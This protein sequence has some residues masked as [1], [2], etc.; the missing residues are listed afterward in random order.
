MST[1]LTLPLMTVEQFFA[2]PEPTG[3]F[4]CELHFGELIEVSR[5]NKRHFDLQSRIRDILVRNLNS[6]LWRIDIEMPYGL[7]AGYDARAA[8]VGVSRRE[9]WDA[10]PQD[11]YLIGSPDLV[12]EIKSRSN[13]DR[14]MEADAIAHITHGATA[15]ALVNPD[16]GEVIVVTASART[17]YGRADRIDSRPAFHVYLNGGNLPGLTPPIQ[18]IPCPN[19]PPSVSALTPAGP[20][21]LPYRDLPPA[22]SSSNAAV[23]KP[24]TPPSPAP[25]SPITPPSHS[26]SKLRK[27]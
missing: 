21:P 5:P 14:K 3:D 27:R 25:S 15:V 2:L 26:A 17:V 8:D 13:R 18:R 22:P 24:P 23:S 12:I 7:T 11:G 6:R 16:R 9:I 10:V 19:P 20:A 4:T 1:A